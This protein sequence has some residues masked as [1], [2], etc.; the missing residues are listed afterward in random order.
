M[1]E[2]LGFPS[3][4]PGLSTQV[5]KHQ[6]FPVDAGVDFGRWPDATSRFMYHDV[7]PELLEGIDRHTN[8]ADLGGAN[9]L[10]KEWLPNSITID[11]DESKNP[12]VVADISFYTGDHDLLVLR[13]VLHYFDDEEAIKLFRHLH[14][15]HRGSVL[16]IQFVNEDLPAKYANSHNEVKYFRNQLQL[17]ML[18]GGG[19]WRIA[20]Q[21]TV[22]YKVEAEF[23]RNRLGGD[24]TYT[25][26]DEAVTSILLE[27]L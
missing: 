24:H 10:L 14:S 4:N 11:T 3:I 16:I 5:V 27:A 22:S 9:G 26:H 25:G 7:M 2:R 21:T 17:A 15:Y 8:V 23:Y 20:N 6:R 12:D 18:F 19:L 13:Y 1:K